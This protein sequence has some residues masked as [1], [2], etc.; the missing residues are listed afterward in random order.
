MQS[1]YKIFKSQVID[2]EILEEIPVKENIPTQADSLLKQAK[3][4]ALQ[5]ESQSDQLRERL[6][7][8]AMEKALPEIEMQK[9]KAFEEAKAAGYEEGYNAGYDKGYLK[10]IEDVGYEQGYILDQAREVLIQA[11][12]KSKTIIESS[13]DRILELS[14]KISEK[15]VKKE[16]EKDDS[17]AIGIVR[18][19]LHEV[20]AA[21]HITLKVSPEDIP[22]M[23]KSI[24]TF[25]E[26]CPD[27]YFTILKDSGMHS[28]NCIVETDKV[29][30]D[31]CI[32][33]QL[34]E[35]KSL[36]TRIKEKEE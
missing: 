21:K 24:S 27:A 18:S 11:V 1:S 32:D 20:R 29:V 23:N 14:L 34:E 7:N 5:I 3:N 19:A 35:I 30:V 4:K 8:E 6:Y 33:S 9:A 36:L 17:I 22:V 31:A 15:I 28:P 26:I 10:A 25:K 16:L 12:D 2:E 13:H